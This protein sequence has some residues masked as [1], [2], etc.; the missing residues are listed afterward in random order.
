M[1]ATLSFLAWALFVFEFFTCRTLMNILPTYTVAVVNIVGEGLAPW[2]ENDIK[3]FDLCNV[4]SGVLPPAIQEQLARGI[5][6]IANRSPFPY[7][8]G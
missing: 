6:S 2:G 5:K 1:E 4:S 7:T 3:V 8:T